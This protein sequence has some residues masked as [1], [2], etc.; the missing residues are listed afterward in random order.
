MD[1]I[2]INGAGEEVI[3][4]DFYE[5]IE[6]PKFVELT[7]PDRC[8]TESD[9]RYW[10][11]LRVGCDQN[12]DEEMD[13]EAI[14]KNFVLRVMA[15]RSPSVRLRQALSRKDSSSNL[16]CPRTV[17]AK[18]SKSRVSRLA[19]IS[20]ISQKM[21]E[22]KV[23]VRCVPKQSATTPNVKAAK[24]PSTKALTT[25]R[26]KKGL[27]N[28]GAF[29][30]V[31]NPKPTTIEVPKNRVVAKALVFHSPKKAV[32]LKKSVE[33]SSSLRKICAGMKKREITEKNTLGCNKPLDASRKQLR[34]RE[35]K[36]RV[37]DSLHSHN[38]KK[39]EAKSLTCL[40]KK[41]GKDLQLSKGSMCH[42]PNEKD[43][44]DMEIEAKSKD[45]SLEVCSTS[46]I[47]KNPSESSEQAID[48][49][50]R[51]STDASRNNVA[52]LSNSEGI[53]SGDDDD[54]PKSQ[55]G[56]HNE[57]NERIS[58][59]ENISEDKE[60][61]EATESDDKEN[62]LASHIK[63]SESKVMEIDDEENA[64]AS[65]ENRKLNCTTVKVVK[66]DVLGKHEASKG[67]KKV[68]KVMSN[69]LKEN[70]TSTINGTQG[71]KYRKPKLTYPKPFRLRTDERGIL[72]EA[73]LEKKHLQAPLKETTTFPGFQ[74]GNSRRKSQNVQRK[75]KC[76]GQTETVC[77]THEGSDN[78]S[79]TRKLKDRPKTI[80]SCRSR[81][82]RG[83]MERK[84]ST[85]PQ[86]RAV[87][88]HQKTKFPSLLEKGQDK[89]AQKSEGT[90][91]KTKLSSIKQLATPGGV[92]SSGT[93]LV[94]LMKPGQ[95]G[96]MKEMSPT[97][98]RS[99]QPS[100]PNE[101]ET[102]LAT[103][104]SASNASSKKAYNHSKGATLS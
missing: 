47:S 33:L 39:P 27:S 57:I 21:G 79:D 60:I 35:V 13:S 90:L 45:G 84:L 78:E 17:P 68:T 92:A 93:K 16:Q 1:E 23:K 18:S 74:D 55:N 64:S 63:A 42:K 103:K 2:Q 26:N 72:K 71:M 52:S 12:H 99:K 88:M 81:I 22:V 41:K 51:F 62:A 34:G 75:E 66:N 37:Y 36:S 70:P 95:L 28:P 43:S 46:G 10:F 54:V 32:M 91:E 30:S 5:K 14:Y 38:Q 87:P 9:D 49:K 31:R 11:C 58:H 73:N 61:P 25:P 77:C 86:K 80:K 56:G 24:Q 82:S 48:E 19:M 7:A 83:T 29:R 101:S 89:A 69:T 67:I 3:G 100:Y 50:V 59:E 98:S 96:V 76:L 44:T 94:S 102:S 65:D 85:A 53:N 97:M 104:A 40:K 20:S 15:A 4:D 8:R 6:A